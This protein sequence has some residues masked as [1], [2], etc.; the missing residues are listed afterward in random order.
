MEPLEG[1]EEVDRLG[2]SDRPDSASVQ[3]RLDADTLGIDSDLT[4]VFE[5]NGQGSSLP[6]LAE[7]DLY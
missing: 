2:R 7:I 1:S 3:A 6:L 5:T 4:S